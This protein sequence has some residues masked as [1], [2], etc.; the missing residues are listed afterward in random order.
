MENIS[1]L[2][3]GM[4]AQLCDYSKNHL[5]NHILSKGDFFLSKE[6]MERNK[7]LGMS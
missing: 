2:I 3:V 6:N 1:K 7:V 4:V 5:I